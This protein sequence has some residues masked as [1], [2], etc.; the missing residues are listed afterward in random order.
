M[1]VEIFQNC[2][3]FIFYEQKLSLKK[4]IELRCIID[5]PSISFTGGITVQ[6]Q[7]RIMAN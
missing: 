1:T 2:I 6:I 3:S 5:S 4:E 7:S